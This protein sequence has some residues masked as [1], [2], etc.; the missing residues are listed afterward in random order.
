M[1]RHEF[2][3]RS[4]LAVGIAL[5]LVAGV[6]LLWWARTVF[7]LLF[8]GVVFGVFLNGVSEWV[9]SR[10]KL[11]YFG[12]LSIVAVLLVAALGL[13]GWLMGR[14]I[15]SQLTQLA[16]SL[17]LILGQ[18]QE[19]IEQHQWGRWLI[20]KAENG[21]DFS[22]GRGV[23]SRVTGLV[24]A[25]LNGLTGIIVIGFIGL[26]GAIEPRYYR[27]GILH[28]VPKRHRPRGEEVL[29]ALDN[30]LLRWL[31][32]RL[33]S[34]LI[35]GIL[36]TVGLWFLGVPMALA[37]GLLAFCLEAIPNV[38]PVLA[39]VPAILVAWSQGGGTLALETFG[40]FVAIQTIEGYILLPVIQREA[41]YLPPILSVIA[42]VFFGAIGGILGAFI[43]APLLVVLMVLV[44][45][46]YIE[47]ALND[48]TV[49]SG[50]DE[51]T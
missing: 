37:L 9:Q 27:K 4:F 14:E 39:S 13:A 49:K 20:E 18:F 40:L 21:S 30:S 16:D 44:K 43:A 26:Y 10:T 3:V 31:K 28:L 33:L 42:V 47:D 5:L 23:I 46:L 29:E 50:T 15:A 1:D 34:M 32:A 35:I 11:P 25:L 6:F 24:G 19:Q 48:H 7:F 51:A 12:S 17:P 36:T 45:L 8:A 38:G 41:V 2:A 22:G